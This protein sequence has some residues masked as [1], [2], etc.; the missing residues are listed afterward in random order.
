MTDLTSMRISYTRANL[1]RQDLDTSPFEQF[2]EW[3]S[4]ALAADLPEPYAMSLATANA[5]GRPSVR[6]VLLRKIDERGL[7][8]YTNYDSQKGQELAEQTHAEALFYWAELERQVRISGQVE[9]LS[10]QE[11]AAYFRVRPRESQLA[12][13]VSTPQSAPVESREVLEARFAEVTAQYEGEEIPLPD[14]WGGY[15][16]R[17][18]TWEFWQGR[19]NRMHDR[20]E[21]RREADGADKSAEWNIRRL[22]P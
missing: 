14:F 7:S 21:Y 8:F 3:L 18:E 6:I 22:M 13:H 5:A 12:A 15:V 2:E 17:P 16:L 11:S 1:R 4:E 19:P 20:F 10:E 9:R